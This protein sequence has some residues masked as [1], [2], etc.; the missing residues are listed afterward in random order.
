MNVLADRDIPDHSPGCEV[1]DRDVISLAVAD[2]EFRDPVCGREAGSNTRKDKQRDRQPMNLAA[3]NQPLF[4][5]I[6]SRPSFS[7]MPTPSAP[8]CN[9]LGSFSQVR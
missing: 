9:A 5:S 6:G 3:H 1:N 4:S 2:V 7:L 8:F